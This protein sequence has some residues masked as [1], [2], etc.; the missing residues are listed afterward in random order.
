M[1]HHRCT[2]CKRESYPRHKH[3][4]GV[5]CDDC[6]RWIRGNVGVGGRRGWFGSLWDRL[7]EFIATPFRG[8]QTEEDNRRAIDRVA[9]TRLKS[10]EAKA[11]SIPMNP[12]SQQPQ[13]R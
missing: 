13:K 12:A 7:M 3:M 4:G 8:P 2:R 10:M 11:R 5:Y 1:A 9:H 6:I